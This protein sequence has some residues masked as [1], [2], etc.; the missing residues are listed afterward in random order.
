MNPK[1]RQQMII[2]SSVVVVAVLV[3]AVLIAVSQQRTGASIDF[4]SI[5]QS[6]T[7]DGAYVLGNPDAAVTIVEFADFAC[8]HC[9]QYRS[10]IERF[11]QEHVANGDAKFEFRLF[12]TV[13]GAMSEFAG[14]VGQCAEEQEEGAFWRAYEV[15]YELAETG[16]YNDQM[17]RT[18]A[19]RLELDYSQ[20]LNCTSNANQ[21]AID[22]ALG[23]R[24]GVTGTPAV[25]VRYG[26]S[27]PTYINLGGRAYNSGGVPYEV[28]EQAVRPQ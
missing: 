2:I 17:G 6:R 1:K 24:V 4:A 18:V 11:I 23:R 8:P 19:D 13:G 21:P 9:Q 15:F 16:R 5:P 22:L 7:D 28:L 27:E 14:R 10:T 25:M 26:N 12:P 3:I 20:L